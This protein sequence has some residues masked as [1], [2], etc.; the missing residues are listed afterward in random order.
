M[1]ETQKKR[2]LPLEANP[3]IMTEFSRGLGVPADVSFHDVYG[4][5][6]VLLDMVPK[7]VLAVLLLFP[8]SKESEEAK[9]AEEERILKYGQM[10][11]EKV[12]F[13]KQTVG[14][15]CGTVGLLHSF[16]NNIDKLHAAE[17][18]YLDRFFKATAGMTP[19]ERARYLED[20]TELGIAH[21]VAA[22]AGDTEPPEPAASVDLHFIA[23]VHVNGGLYELDGRKLFPIFHGP[24]SDQ[25]LLL[26]A[27]KVAQDFIS[28]AAGN[29]NFNVIALCRTTG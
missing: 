24:S 19:D 8:I 7:P 1:G 15:A 23:L 21:E 6:D 4:F 28:R 9:K 11:S 14:N 2:W 25:T 17:G 27:A 3:E 18:S 13:M 22:A 26:D 12:Y 29:V 20:D 16:G 10:V 5:D